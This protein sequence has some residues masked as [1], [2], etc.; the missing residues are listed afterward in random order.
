VKNKKIT[1][2][3]EISRMKVLAGVSDN[4]ENVVEE[5][6]LAR[7]AAGLGIALMS[8]TNVLAQSGDMNK[9]KY[10]DDK[11]DALENAL[12]NPVVQEKL[13]EL[14]VTDNNI[15]KEIELVKGRE[16]TGYQEKTVTSDRQLKMLL[17]SGWHLTS[18]ESDTIINIVKIQAPELDIDTIQLP[19]NE[20][21][22]FA[23]GR[24]VIDLSDSSNIKA[25]LDSISSTQSN[26]LNVTIISS[27]DKQGLSQKLQA[28]LSSMG[29]TADNPGL[30]KAR[31]DGVKNALLTLG[32]DS[33]I[34]NQ[35][36]KYEQ[37]GPVIDQGARYVVVIFDVVKYPTVAP[38]ESQVEKVN[39]QNTYT[40]FKP[41]VKV[42]TKKIGSYKVKN[43]KTKAIK[44]NKKTTPQ[45]CFFGQG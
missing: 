26:L 7:V 1:L 40:L 4:N 30:S 15:Q 22:M 11:K 32:V 10:S 35:D 23:S 41:V 20:E 44:Y 45:R 28:T 33:S 29:Y 39:V 9:L 42:G 16:V 2:N 6:V 36:I 12:E 31:N 38:G 37:G 21:A 13:K 25:L 3:E 14:G 17:K 34:I 24:F 5:G 19:M 43:C 18:V 8:F 27:T